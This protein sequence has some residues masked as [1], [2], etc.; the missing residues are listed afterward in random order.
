MRIVN[1]RIRWECDTFAVYVDGVGILWIKEAITDYF[2]RKQWKA[3]AE[4]V[5]L[6]KYK[7]GLTFLN[8]RIECWQEAERKRILNNN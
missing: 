1:F 3:T 6:G 5:I 4:L 8:K 7:I 2:Y